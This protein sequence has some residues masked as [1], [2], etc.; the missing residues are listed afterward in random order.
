MEQ[1]AFGNRKSY[2]PGF[3]SR[4]N[5]YKAD[6]F[7]QGTLRCLREEVGL[8]CPPMPF[9]TNDSESINVFL[10]GSLK[11]KKQQWPLFNEKV[12]K[13]VDQQQSEI[14]KGIIGYGQ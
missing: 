3:H 7:R 12:R 13:I 2:Q 4:F 11:Y 10:K 5:K 1:N 8:G 6:D 14:E 9:F